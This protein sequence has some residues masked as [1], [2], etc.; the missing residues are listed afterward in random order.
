MDLTKEW[1]RSEF[2]SHEML[3]EY[4]DIENELHFYNAITNGDKEYI[5]NNIKNKTFTNPDGMGLLSENP[6]QNI[7]YHFVVTTAM[8]TR[9]CVHAGMEQAKAYKLSDFYISKMDKCKTIAEISSLHDTMCYDF[10]K[11]MGDLKKS[12]ILSKPIVLCLDYIYSHIHFR[13][14]V[15]ELAEHINLSETY[16]SKLFKKEMGIPISQYII[17][18]KIEKAK[19]LLQYSDYN[20]VDIAN[21]LSFSSQSHFIQVFQK[22]TGMSPHKFRT[23]YFR[24]SWE[25]VDA[26]LQRDKS[27]QKD[28]DAKS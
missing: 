3:E 5:D 28:I 10:C 16:L 25:D 11:R 22:K 4:R 2:I 14:T 13:I 1:Y 26:P 7:R 24:T 18:L 19:N 6:L 21:N 8:I 12:Q 9:Y 15:K 17:S 20:I 27:P 23:R